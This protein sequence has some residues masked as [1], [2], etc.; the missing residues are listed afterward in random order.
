MHH[1]EP[2]LPRECQTAESPGAGMD[3]PT[4]A[5]QVTLLFESVEQD[6]ELPVRAFSL[7]IARG[8]RPGRGL[9]TSTGGHV[10]FV[11]AAAGP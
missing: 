3:Q 5:E 7:I 11:G 10:Y 1:A 2:G 9:R 6:D 8:V 4:A